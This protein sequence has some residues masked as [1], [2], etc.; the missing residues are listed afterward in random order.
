M[1][2]S[3][4]SQYNAGKDDRSLWIKTNGN[5]TKVVRKSTSTKCACDKRNLSDANL[6]C[7]ESR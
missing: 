7:E 1:T 5:L 2:T 3:T 4:D 6:S